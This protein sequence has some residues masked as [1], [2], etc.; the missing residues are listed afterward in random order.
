MA[1]LFRVHTLGPLFFNARTRLRFNMSRNSGLVKER[2]GRCLPAPTRRGRRRRFR[3]ARPDRPVIELN[4]HAIRGIDRAEIGPGNPKATGIVHPA[5]GWLADFV[6]Q[7]ELPT[8]LSDEGEAR[9]SRYAPRDAPVKFTPCADASVAIAAADTAIALRTI[10]I[11]FSLITETSRPSIAD[12]LRAFR[13]NACARL[14][15]WAQDAAFRFQ[16]QG[17][18]W[19][20]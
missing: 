5:P 2:R 18:W 3:R 11:A 7:V 20:Q 12:R 19:A 17:G 16:Q 6:D 9:P 1:G 10:L 13:C 15:F 8:V 4:G 14:H